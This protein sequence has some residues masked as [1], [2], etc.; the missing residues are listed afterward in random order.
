L[1]GRNYVVDK[2]TERGNLIF[3]GYVFVIR[4]DWNGKLLRIL[5]YDK[6]IFRRSRGRRCRRGRRLV[7]AA[8]SAS[9]GHDP[10]DY[11]LSVHTP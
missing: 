2:R 6:K 3:E 4:L 5:E 1:V 9:T 11:A 8:A 7:I 10:T